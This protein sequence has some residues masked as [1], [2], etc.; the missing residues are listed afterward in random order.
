MNP[1]TCVLTSSLWLPFTVFSSDVRHVAGPPVL[2]QL[3]GKAK[4]YQQRAVEGHTRSRQG[5][6]TLLPTGGWVVIF[7]L[8]PARS[9]GPLR[10]FAHN[11][12]LTA[13]G[14]G[15]QLADAEPST[16]TRSWVQ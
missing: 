15:Q 14:F 8:L 5:L 6:H 4:L 3:W 7:I 2:W 16:E 9:Q 1:N 12:H 10:F 13:F 11:P